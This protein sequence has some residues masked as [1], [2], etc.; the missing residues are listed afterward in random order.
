MAI[1]ACRLRCSAD[2]GARLA[3]RTHPLFKRRFQPLLQHISLLLR[4]KIVP[5]VTEK[6]LI[7][8]VLAEKLSFSCLTDWTRWCE[9]RLRLHI[10]RYVSNQ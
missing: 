4:P 9:H 10:S 7:D 5:F 3:K 8:A 1:W 2:D 6:L